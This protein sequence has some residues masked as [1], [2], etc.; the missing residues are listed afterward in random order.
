MDAMEEYY[1]MNEKKGS[2]SNDSILSDVALP[3][4]N[5]VW[6][7]QSFQIHED[8]FRGDHKFNQAKISSETSL[9]PCKISMMKIFSAWKVS[10]YGVISGP[11]LETFHAVTGVLDAPLKSN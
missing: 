7:D 8:I 5:D 6:C 4:Y 9:G 3:E 2:V 10:K 11:Y 1:L